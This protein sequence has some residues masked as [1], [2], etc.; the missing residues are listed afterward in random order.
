MSGQGNA[1]GAQFDSVVAVLDHRAGQSPFRDHVEAHSLLKVIGSVAGLAV[2]DLSCHSGQYARHF[3]TSGAK[4]V[5][6]VDA[7]RTMIEYALRREEQEHL[8][9][10]YVHHDAT[11]D[12]S[13]APRLAGAF[14]LV[15]AVHVLPS[16]QSEAELTAMCATARQ[17]MSQQGGRFVAMTLNP[18]CATDPQWYQ[19]YGLTLATDPPGGE[20][21]MVHLPVS[22]DGNVLDADARRWS[23][24]AHEWAL[25]KAGFS[26]VDWHWPQVSAEGRW[27]YGSDF[28][29]NYLTRPHALIIDADTGYGPEIT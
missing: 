27:L 21:A 4:K 1:L 28:W 24:G 23:I 2:L 17:A 18:N 8:G 3:R 13:D 22:A 26:H 14:D 9:I 15:T 20:G 5:V 29:M 11:R 7:S 10:T 16:A 12:L 6:G 25:R 19:N